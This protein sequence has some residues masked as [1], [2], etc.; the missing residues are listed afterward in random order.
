MVFYVENHVIFK[1]WAFYFFSNLDSF[2]LFF[3]SVAMTSTFKLCW[4]TVVR[5]DI[6]VLFLIVEEVLSVIHYCGCFLWVCYICP[7]L[8]WGRF[9]LCWLS[10]EVF[11]YLF[12]NHERMLNFV[13]DYVCIYWDYHIIFIFQFDRTMYHVVWFVY[14]EE[15][16]HSWD[17]GHLIMMYDIF[18][19]LLDSVC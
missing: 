19:V 9:L 10:G 3:S 18:N 6:L 4:I 11:I 1:Q 14:S 8:C 17:T 12:F 13:K 5:V 2:Y 16:L 15:S 7:L